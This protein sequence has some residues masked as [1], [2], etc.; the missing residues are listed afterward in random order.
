VTSTAPTLTSDTPSFEIYT[1]DQFLDSKNQCHSDIAFTVM[2]NSKSLD[3]QVV[4]RVTGRFRG[5]SG[6]TSPGFELTTGDIGI[7]K[8]TLLPSC[9]LY[10]GLSLAT[11][12]AAK[13]TNRVELKDWLW[14]SGQVINAWWNAVGRS[15]YETGITFSDAWAANSWTQKLLVGGVTI[16]GTRL[17]ARIASRSLARGKDDSRYDAAKTEPGFWKTALFKVFLPEALFLSVIS[18]PVTMP[19]SLDNTAISLV[20]DTSSTLRALGVGLFSAGFALE[21]L[22]DT[23]LELHRQERDDLCRHGVWSIVRHPK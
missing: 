6:V 13:A 14:P 15:M 12:V 18:L 1:T 2:S 23:Q 3:N 20:S 22:A 8:S 19:F 16:W 5:P 17:F 21:V 9:G 11:F 4:E 10:S 7:L